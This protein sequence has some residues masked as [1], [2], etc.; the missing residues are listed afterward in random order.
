[1]NQKFLQVT[2]TIPLKDRG[3][4]DVLLDAH[5]EVEKAI[6]TGQFQ[7]VIR[8]DVTSSGGRTEGKY[9]SY[10]YDISLKNS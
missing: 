9:G 1:M 2:V 4:W 10:G 6:S 8:G 5:K 3:N 7:G